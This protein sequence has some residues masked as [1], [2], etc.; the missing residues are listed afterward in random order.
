[1]GLFG[2]GRATGSDAA[3]RQ[4]EAAKRVNQNRGRNTV[5]VS[6]LQCAKTSSH[7]RPIFGAIKRGDGRG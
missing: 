4:A 3:T 7:G 1:M 6:E 2:P 5:T